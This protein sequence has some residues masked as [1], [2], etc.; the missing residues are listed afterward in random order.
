MNS[1]NDAGQKVH[2]VEEADG[3]VENEAVVSPEERLK[4]AE[5]IIKD[6][7]LVGA[8]SGL[9]PGPGIDMVLAFGTQLNLV[10]R[11]SQLYGVPFRENAAKSTIT[12]LF[13]SLGAVGAGAIAA[14]SFVKAIPVLGTAVGVAG[15]SVSIGAFTYAIGK[16]FQQHFESNGTFLDLDPGAYRAYFREMMKRGKKVAEDE[17]EDIEEVVVVKKRPT[18]AAKP[19]T[20]EAGA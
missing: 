20:V 2:L 7:V 16:V 12:A 6:H 14:M 13:G 8:A 9:V 10:R 19:A 3:Q 5:K 18:A 17:A 4:R 15:T 11:L 1:V